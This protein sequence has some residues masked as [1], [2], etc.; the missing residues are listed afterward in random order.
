MHIDSNVTQT[1]C[2]ISIVINRLKS[3]KK[4]FPTA[5][6]N[7]HQPSFGHQADWIDGFMHQT[8]INTQ[9]SEK[10]QI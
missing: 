2:V 6:Y 5:L 8:L 9:V 3:P 4:T 7:L 10:K 1:G